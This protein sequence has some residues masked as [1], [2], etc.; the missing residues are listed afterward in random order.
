M[1]PQARKCKRPS[2]LLATATTGPNLSK[3]LDGNWNLSRPPELN[4]ERREKRSFSARIWTRRMGWNGTRKKTFTIVG[5]FKSVRRL[6]PDHNWTGFFEEKVRPHRKGEAFETFVGRSEREI[7]GVDGSQRS[8]LDLG[9]W[10]E[11][12]KTEIVA[13]IET[14]RRQV[15]SGRRRAGPRSQRTEE[16][17]RRR[18]QRRR[19]KLDVELSR[20]EQVLGVSWSNFVLTHWLVMAWSGTNHGARFLFLFSRLLAPS[21]LPRVLY[22]WSFVIFGWFYDSEAN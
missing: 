19:L 14:R 12:G 1:K 7:E 9:H 15:E 17:R 18:R 5:S 10:T 6:W 4:S 13:R 16:D 22:Y 11:H 3:K 20:C 21:L 8:E 2:W